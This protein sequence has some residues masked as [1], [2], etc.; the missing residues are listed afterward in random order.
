MT[1]VAATGCDVMIDGHWNIAVLSNVMHYITNEWCTDVIGTGL[2]TGM[3]N[4]VGGW[5]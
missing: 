1:G 3:I 5:I 4:R 2:Q